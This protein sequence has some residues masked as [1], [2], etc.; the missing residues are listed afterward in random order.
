MRLSVQKLFRVIFCWTAKKLK[1][2]LFREEW[3]LMGK[4][5]APL[6][7]GFHLSLE[8]MTRD[9]DSRDTESN[10]SKRMETLC[11]VGQLFNTIIKTNR[12]I[13]TI[14]WKRN[15]SLSVLIGRW[16]S[17]HPRQQSCQSILGAST[18]SREQKALN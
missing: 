10:G 17:C 6:K 16:Q 5:W 8:V 2:L 1:R 18:E 13:I 12:M 7:K 3:E 11:D 4:Q 9:F 15:C 14:G